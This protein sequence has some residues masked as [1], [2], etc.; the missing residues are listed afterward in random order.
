LQKPK[1]RRLPRSRPM[2][3][4]GNREGAELRGSVEADRI[5]LRVLSGKHP[6]HFRGRRD[7]RHQLD[8]RTVGSI[9]RISGDEESMR[10]AICRH[11]DGSPRAP[12]LGHCS[13]RGRHGLADRVRLQQVHSR[14]ANGWQAACD[15]SNGGHYKAT[16]TCLPWDGGKA[17]V[18]DSAGWK[19]SGPSFAFCPPS[20]DVKSGGILTKAS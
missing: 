1:R 14:G 19:S 3:G 10:D 11:G 2:Q 7:A 5:F 4:P 13:P 8:L 15:K 9:E 6:S 20:S 16:V 17:I 12:G 18:R